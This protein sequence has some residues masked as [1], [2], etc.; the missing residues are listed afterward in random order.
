MN[1]EISFSDIEEFE[2][3]FDSDRANILA[4]NAVTSNGINKSAKDPVARAKNQFGFSVEVEAG[5]VCD[6]KHSGRCWMFA[7]YNVMRLEIMKKLKLENMELS[8]N[9]PLFYDKLEK[10]NH[11]L[12]NMIEL[13]DEPLDGRVISFLLSDPMG[14]GGQWD[15]FRSLTAKYGVVPKDVMPETEVS[16]QT[17]ELDTYL[18]AKLREFAS[19]FRKRH[20]NGA[21]EDELRQAKKE[22]MSTIYRMLVISLGKPPVKFTWETR[23]KD[24]KFI[25]VADITP[26][27]FFKEY[28]GWDLDEYVTVI[29]APTK[30]KPY[31]LTY[32]V[33]YLGNVVD[34]AYS[35]KYLNLP[36]DD[37]R[38]LAISQLKDGKAVWFGSDVG[39]FSDRKGGYLTSDILN[40]SGLFN[41][42]FGMTKEE[43]LDYGDSMMTHAMVITGVDLDDSGKPMRWKV[44]NS[45]GEEVGEKGFYVMDDKWFGE[46]AFQIL[47]EKKYLSDEQRKAFDR[48]PVILKPWDPMGSLA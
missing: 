6:Q 37:L 3:A 44:E 11:F 32:T 17:N 43:R 1:K 21:S 18:T 38:S 23:D 45:W 8:Q 28:V 25:R 48:D 9:Y 12:E 14:D 22:M 26:V 4:M 36:M 5:K 7:S 19:V 31:G 34:G 24:K 41:T 15:M 2:A 27:E 29:N 10:A 46:F 39:Q 20:A 33:Q 47:L 35:V 30:D 42:G 13:I 40:V 16:G